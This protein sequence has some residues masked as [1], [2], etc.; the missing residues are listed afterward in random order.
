MLVLMLAACSSDG[1]DPVDTGP[2]YYRDVRPILDM[3][4]ARCHTDRG[5]SISFDD[6]VSV[7]SLATSIQA[8]TQAGTMP[9]PAPDPSC[10]DYEG[11][12]ALFL[13]DEDKQ[14]LSDWADAGA[15]L[16]DPASAPTDL[17]PPLTTAPFDVELRGSEPYQPAFDE[18]GN[19]YR[20]FVLDAG[21]DTPTYVTGFEA[22]VDN[23]RIVHHVVL[24]SVAPTVTLPEV[25]TGEVGF[26]C[27]GFGESNWEF[28]AGWAPG[29]R[30][31][32]F[33]EG[34]GM[35]M[36]AATRL[37]LQMHYYESFDGAAA[38]L[39]QSGYGLHL[40]DDVTTE[41]F[42]L[43]LGVEDFEI[44]AGQANADAQM[45]VPWGEDWGDVT[46]VG[47][48]PHMHLLGTGFDFN[49]QHPDGTNTC[50]VEMNDWDF[51]NQQAVQLKEPVRIEGGD[52]V[53]VT[54][55]WDNSAANPNQPYEPPRD[56]VFGEGTGDEM[57]YAFTYG[58]SD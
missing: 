5:L 27:D 25:A 17:A 12:E 45:F 8:R 6:P 9:P 10:A 4:C 37:V 32:Q 19:D 58:F 11:S 42:A 26:A 14:T 1:Q 56:V 15:P 21:N 47:T 52:I 51:H 48:F 20:C 33:D 55:N 46:I 54:C 18:T 24:W 38:E 31:V 34:Q 44:P 49:V 36:R 3:S 2:T 35:Q 30:P 29:G 13:S 23:P 7:Q 57:C 41:L 53:T 39:D 43:P 50:V 40:S 28:F 22:L 16:G